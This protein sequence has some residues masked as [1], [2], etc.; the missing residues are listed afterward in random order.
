MGTPAGIGGLSGY[1][2]GSGQDGGLGG[3]GG[4]GHGSAIMPGGGSGG[5]GG[6]GGG[7]GGGGQGGQGGQGGLGGQGGSGGAG[8]GGTIKLVASVLTEAAGST[9]DTRGGWSPGGFG[10]SSGG[11]GRFVLARNSAPEYGGTMIGSGLIENVDAAGRHLGTRAPNSYIT[12]QPILT[13]MI[14]GLLGGADAFGVAPLTAND[15]GLAAA[16]ADRPADAVGALCLMDEGPASLAADWDGFDMLLFVNLDDEPLK[17]PCLGIGQGGALVR[18]AQ[19]G[20]A[21]NAQFGGSGYE[22][23]A[24]LAPG[25]VYATLVPEGSGHFSML[26]DGCELT[27]QEALGVG[28]AMYMTPEPATLSL[29]AFGALVMARR[30]RSK[31]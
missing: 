18:L 4:I 23:L 7:G 22:D 1:G 3:N 27:S 30:R 25:G 15:P 8:A 12:G 13:P 9:I 24:S 29:L 11:N 19:G 28:A 20:F 21:R 10:A 17:L 16:M 6:A 14:P 31:A 5:G 2:G 26:A